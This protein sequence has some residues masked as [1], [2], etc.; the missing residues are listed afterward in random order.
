MGRISGFQRLVKENFPAKYRDIVDSFY[1]LNNALEQMV[2][3]INT[4]QITV[5]DN[6]NQQ[7]KTIIVTVNASGTP[8]QP[9]TYQ[10]ML[11]SKTIGI[12]VIAA[13]NLT[14]SSTFPTSCPFISFSDNSGTVTISNVV[15]LQA[16]QSYNL[17]LLATG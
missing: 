10:S 8:I 5:T 2:N 16:N 1:P 9:L 13:N 12:T 3:I 17:T 11:T 14:N 6:M 15:G 7:Y 4:N